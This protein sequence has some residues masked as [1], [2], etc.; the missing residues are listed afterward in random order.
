[1]TVYDFQPSN[2]TRPSSCDGQRFRRG[3][4]NLV[5]A[6]ARLGGAQGCAMVHGSQTLLEAA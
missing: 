3:S 1:M 6:K 4:A 2:S 5:A